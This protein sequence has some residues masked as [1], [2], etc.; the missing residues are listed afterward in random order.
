MATKPARA[1]S[2]VSV[3][4]VSKQ[5]ARVRLYLLG[6]AL[7][8][9]TM[10]GS[11]VLANLLVLGAWLGEP[12]KPHGLVLF[13]MI[14]PVY[15]L[16]AINGGAYGIRML[17]NARGSA[18]HALLAF[19]QAV[20]VTLLLIF[21]AKISEQISR[22]TFLVGCV[23]SVGGL[24]ACRLF[25]RAQARRMLGEVPRMEVFIH[26]GAE[27]VDLPRHMSV[28]DA[29]AIGLDPAQHDAT[30]A[31]RL[32]Q[33]VGS[34]EHV[35]V[36][37]AS[38]KVGEWS[39][40]LKSLSA[41]GEIIVPE[42]ARYAP[43]RGGT[44]QHLPTLVVAGGPL[45]FRDRVVKRMFDIVV[46]AGAILILSPVLIATAFAVRLSSPGPILFRQ[47]RIG[48]DARPFSIFKFRSMRVENSDHRADRLT[49][50]DDPRVTRVG[51]FIRRTS[52]DEL[53][54]L[55]NVLRGD[56]SIVGPRP[57]APGAKAADALYWE[58]DP[59]Y[60]ARHCIK[61]GITGLA[62]VRGHRGNT[63]EHEDLILRLQSD[64]EYVTGWSVWR[65]LRIL[66]ATIGVLVHHNAY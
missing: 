2:V 48:L 10:L 27:T 28:V 22:L 25:V 3:P 62:Q 58:V 18:A 31:E 52:L 30:M 43:A 17:S 54:Q 14:A 49:E 12:N 50:K 55:F 65:D 38:D 16:L 19:G 40:A 26:D 21:L 13:A 51:A 42:M 66:A 5:N 61:P 56:M 60:W 47:Q 41:R 8:M 15:A 11:F 6:L 63:V 64:L 45:D 7:D 46:S 23:L 57:H 29:R 35:V 36:S 53:P 33:A 44:F 4:P 34:A 24:V 59:R 9:W 20:L 39:M 1:H 37:C 32:A